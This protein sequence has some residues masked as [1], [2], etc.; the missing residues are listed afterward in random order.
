[1]CYPVGGDIG[2]GNEL[3]P[4]SMANEPISIYHWA[5]LGPKSKSSPSSEG[6]HWQWKLLQHSRDSTSVPLTFLLRVSLTGKSE[7]CVKEGLVTVPLV[8]GGTGEDAVSVPLLFFR[9]REAE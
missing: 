8:S 2:V 9:N 7:T 5:G 6:F 4:S 1:M 3:V